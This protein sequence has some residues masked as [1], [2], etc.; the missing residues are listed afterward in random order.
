ME[1]VEKCGFY[2][3]H[4]ETIH[5]NEMSR[6]NQSNIKF[7]WCS[8]PKHSPATKETVTSRVGGANILTCGGSFA[9]CH[10]LEKFD[11]VIP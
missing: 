7:P 5:S 10:I 1:L 3:E 4:W 8:H 6:I 2:K 11:D 9:G